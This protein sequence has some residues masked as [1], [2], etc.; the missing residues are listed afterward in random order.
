MLIGLMGAGKTTIGKRL[1]KEV[2]RDFV[3]SDE[4]IEAAAHCSISDIFEI[5][6]ETIFRDLEQRVIKRLLE[7]PNL[8]LATGGGAWMQPA[9]RSLIKEKALSIWLRADLDILVD[10]VERRN[11]RPLLEKGDKRD[12]LKGLIDQR[13][14]VYAEADLTIES[15]DGPHDVVVEKVMETILNHLGEMHGG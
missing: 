10:R 15:G 6:G 8:I 2:A 4:E 12:I 13:Y 1:A 11:H 14:P 7:S 9:I 3:D 5:H